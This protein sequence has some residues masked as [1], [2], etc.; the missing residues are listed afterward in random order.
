MLN[1]SS[2]TGN[3]QSN[4]CQLSM[5]TEYDSA[6]RR[7]RTSSMTFTANGAPRS[8]ASSLAP[9]FACLLM[10]DHLAAGTA[11][12]PSAS[13]RTRFR[14]AS[15]R[16]ST[17]RSVSSNGA[18]MACVTRNIY[19]SRFSPACCRAIEPRATPTARTGIVDLPL[20]LLSN[21][22]GVVA[23][24]VGLWAKAS[25]SPR[26]QAASRQRT[27]H[28]GSA[29]AP[30]SGSSTSPP[31]SSLPDKPA[32]CRHTQ[33][34]TMATVPQRIQTAVGWPVNSTKIAHSIS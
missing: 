30:R 22:I 33:W 18:P 4:A 32:D 12:P 16:A 25:I 5:P 23:G 7:G 31:A 26:S 24:P 3:S 6:A 15:S 34:C 2:T 9:I 29:A 14:S 21:L 17:T 19:A 11:S 8:E 10:S 13:P 28:G 20:L 1:H 27:E